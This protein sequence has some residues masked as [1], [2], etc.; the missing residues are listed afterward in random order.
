MIYTNDQMGLQQFIK[1][2]EIHT[3]VGKGIKNNVV[4]KGVKIT[5]H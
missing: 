4:G 2:E 5:N 3:L 1:K